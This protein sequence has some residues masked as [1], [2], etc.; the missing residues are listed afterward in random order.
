MM[1]AILETSCT[2][3]ARVARRVCIA[4]RRTSMAAARWSR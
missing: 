3:H 4:R 2:S 1:A